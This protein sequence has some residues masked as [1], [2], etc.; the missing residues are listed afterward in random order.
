MRH[1]RGTIIS[2]I[3]QFYKHGLKMLQLESMF[4]NRNDLLKSLARVDLTR[5]LKDSNARMLKDSKTRGLKDLKTLDDSK[6]QRLKDLKTGGLAEKSLARVDLTGGLECLR[7]G[8]LE[9]WKTRGLKEQR[10]RGAED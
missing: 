10:S 5:G 7:T 9:D 1:Q 8:R 3:H 2:A 4:Q 6:T